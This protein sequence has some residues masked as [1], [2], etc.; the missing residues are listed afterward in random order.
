[1]QSAYSGLCLNESIMQ[2]EQIRRRIFGDRLRTL[3]HEADL[4]QEELASRSGLHRTYVSSVERGR[5]NIS[6]ATIYSL[7]DALGI[8]AS[9]FF[10]EDDRLGAS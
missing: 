8:D 1:M 10:D 6:L 7:A 2:R 5:R 9:D 4:S 3:R